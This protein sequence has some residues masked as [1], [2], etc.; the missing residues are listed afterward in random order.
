MH[1]IFFFFKIYDPVRQEKHLTVLEHLV[2]AVNI[3]LRSVAMNCRMRLCHLGEELMP[4][5][6]YVWA[7]MRPSAALKKEI[8]E[9]FNLQICAHHP[10]GA[11]TQ[12]TGRVI[13][14][15]VFITYLHT[16]CMVKLNLWWVGC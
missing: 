2:S 14:P 16:L 3:F 13:S 9:F 5:I 15:A 4:S 10:K 12:D 7:D 11:K 1:L 6:L 8:V